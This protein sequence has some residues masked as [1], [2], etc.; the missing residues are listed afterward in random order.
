MA[1]TPGRDS[2]AFLCQRAEDEGWPE[3]EVVPGLRAR[4]APLPV[5]LALKWSHI[6][7]PVHWEK[8]IADFHAMLAE[9]PP[10]SASDLDLMDMRRAEAE[11]RLVRPPSRSMAVSNSEFFRRSEERVGRVVPHD[12]LHEIV[13]YG[14]RPMFESMKDKA[15]LAVLSQARFEASPMRDR[16]RLAREESMV[17]GIERLAIPRARGGGWPANIAAFEAECHAY[18]L[19]RVSTTLSRGWF[20]EFCL[21]HW[22]ELREHDR[23]FLRE[24]AASPLLPEGTVP[25]LAV[26]PPPPPAP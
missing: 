14:E 4:A 25:P 2:D 23:P 19:K 1:R 11:A 5:L 13:A 21:L 17:I 8:N 20:R 9:G 6:H 7:L 16:L 10:L 22:L 12:L 24:F 3:V 18:G 15:E 26:A